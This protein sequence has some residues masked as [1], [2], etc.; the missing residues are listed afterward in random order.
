MRQILYSREASFKAALRDVLLTLTNNLPYMEGFNAQLSLLAGPNHLSGIMAS[1]LAK[2]S[3]LFL[4]IRQDRT[5][6]E[7]RRHPV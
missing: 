4:R 2:A 5:E 1:L 7:H 3:L 6:I